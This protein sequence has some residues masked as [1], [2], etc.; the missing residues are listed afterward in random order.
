MVVSIV[1]LKLYYKTESSMRIIVVG[2][3]QYKCRGFG[4]EKVWDKH[5]H[6][7]LS[8]AKNLQLSACP[9]EIQGGTD[10]KKSNNKNTPCT[11]SIANKKH[12]FLNILKIQGGA[13]W[14]V[15]KTTPCSIFSKLG[16]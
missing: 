6:C 5:F 16:C 1:R 10:Y 9:I 4:F 8:I 14:L 7:L 13:D 15:S 2:N 3:L 12:S 11:L